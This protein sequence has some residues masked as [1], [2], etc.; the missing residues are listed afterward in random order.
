MK[1]STLGKWWVASLSDELEL[2]ELYD[3]F[4]VLSWTLSIKIKALI[5]F[6][7]LLKI[8]A[9]L[10][11]GSSYFCS[12]WSFS[13]NSFYCSV[14]SACFSSANFPFKISQVYMVAW[15]CVSFKARIETLSKRR[16][17]GKFCC[18]YHKSVSAQIVRPKSTIRIS[19][20]TFEIF[21]FM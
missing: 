2:D 4:W 5:S 15:N 21:F 19:K 20:S 9:S 18:A 16:M 11:L 13:N 17:P 7:K 8:F 12:V 14:I 3:N 1:L 6:W 10:L